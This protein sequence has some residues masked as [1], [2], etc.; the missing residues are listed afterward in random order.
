ML[1]A[2]SFSRSCWKTTLRKLPRD[3]GAFESPKSKTFVRS[4]DRTVCR[5]IIRK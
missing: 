5:S 1:K 2:I 3:T 4:A